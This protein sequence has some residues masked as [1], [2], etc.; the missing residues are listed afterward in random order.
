MTLRCPIPAGDRVSLASG[1][2]VYYHLRTEHGL[3]GRRADALTDWEVTRRNWVSQFFVPV[4]MI[5]VS[6]WLIG[7]S[8]IGPVPTPPTAHQLATGRMDD[9]WFGLALLALSTGFFTVLQRDRARTRR[10]AA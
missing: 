8:L 10:K 2:E 1:R 3:D 4:L 7:Y 9:V 6:L 5:G